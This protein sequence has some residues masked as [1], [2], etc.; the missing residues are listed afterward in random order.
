VHLPIFSRTRCGAQARSSGEQCR[1]RSFPGSKY[2]WAHV[3]RGPLLAG[4]LLGAV[5]SVLGAELWRTAVPSTELQELRVLNEA[6]QPVLRVARESA[7]AAT[8][9][10]ALNALLDEVRELRDLSSLVRSL[11]L[12]ASLVVYGNWVAGSPLSTPGVLHFSEHAPSRLDFELTSGETKRVVLHNVG[13]QRLVASGPDQ[14]TLTYRAAARPGDWPLGYSSNEIVALV[15][16]KL[17]LFAI[18]TD[19][20]VDDKV[21][22]R[23]LRLA[24]FINGVQRAQFS[25]TF[26]GTISMSKGPYNS[27]PLEFQNRVPLT[28]TS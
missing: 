28:D 13:M 15:G 20:F 2:C 3:D 16:G 19:T 26:D 4:A 5:L 21:G 14:T 25:H 18:G 9:A 24:V 6:I 17:T 11:E 22:I 27:M 10:E 1:R 12:D 23:N 8:D 7:P